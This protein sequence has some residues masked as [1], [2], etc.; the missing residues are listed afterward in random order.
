MKIYISGAITG[1][2][3]YKAQFEKAEREVAAQGHTPL[4]PARLEDAFPPLAYEDYMHICFAL[5]DLADCVYMLH[6]WELSAGAQRERA[7][8]MQHGK[9]II[10]A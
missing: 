4:N 7:Y 9:R 5:I 1:N 8:A 2:A 6:G 10:E 3:A